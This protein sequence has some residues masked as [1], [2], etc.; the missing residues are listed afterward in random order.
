M[1]ESIPGA[2][3]PAVEE[4]R[5]GRAIVVP[6]PSPLPYGVVATGQA[7]V[8]RAKHRPEDQ[9]VG[10]V[11]AEFAGVAPHLALDR[12]AATLTAW[13]CTEQRLN[14]FV[15]LAP[16]APAWLVQGEAGG[17]AGLMGSWLPELRGVLDPLGHL[18][19]SSA[20]VSKRAVATTAP[21]ADAAFDGDLLVVDGD[22]YR[23]PG[24]PHGSATIIQ[25]SASGEL[26]VARR[27]VN[28][29]GFDDGPAFLA[30]LERRYAR[31]TQ[32]S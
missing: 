9:P 21:D 4:L 26:T 16:G 27:G 24:V 18:Y 32:P 14:V 25:V 28:D 20:N 6:L 15:P 31:A 8:N 5:A 17:T 1:I 10:M 12:A 30:E 22:P 3:A 19:I 23:T 13:L 29:I 2:V 7:A 11:V